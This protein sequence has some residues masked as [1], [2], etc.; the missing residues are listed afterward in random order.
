M[1]KRRTRTKTC[2]NKEGVGGKIW[3][4]GI[5]GMTHGEYDS[6][7]WQRVKRKLKREDEREYLEKKKGRSHIGNEAQDCN[8]EWRRSWERGGRNWTLTI[9]RWKEEGEMGKSQEVGINHT[10]H[11]R[12]I[13][14]TSYGTSVKPHSSTVPT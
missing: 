4:K 5:E 9:E 11:K 13:E 1:K 7:P 3:T 2:C 12:I 6:A 8:K 14:Y 10:S